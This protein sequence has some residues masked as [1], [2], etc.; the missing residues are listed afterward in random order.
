MSITIKKTLR[1][2][3]IDQQG[4][5]HRFELQKNQIPHLSQHL[6]LKKLSLIAKSP[7]YSFEFFLKTLTTH[8][9]TIKLCQQITLLLTTGLS[10]TNAI[11]F[12][13][14][15]EKNKVLLNLLHHIN[16]QL[17]Q[18][19]PL[20]TTLTQYPSYFNA[21]FC[22]IIRS[23]EA[24]GTLTEA[25]DLLT[26]EKQQALKTTAKLKKAL[27]Y[28]LLLLLSSLSASLALISTILP[29]FTHLFDSFNQSLPSFTLA[30]INISNT[31]KWLLPYT[32]G[33]S[34]ILLTS[35]LLAYRYSPKAK[36]ALQIC[37]LKLPIIGTIANNTHYMKLFRILANILQSQLSILEGL[38][39]CKQSTPYIHYKLKIEHT[40]QHIASG[41]SIYQAIKET[42]LFD[43]QSA[44]LIATAEYSHSL[45][46]IFISL[47][48]HFQNEFEHRTDQIEKLIGPFIILMLSLVIACVIIAIY[49][50]IFNMGN[51]M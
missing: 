20:S 36:K 41:H 51:M 13:I 8:Q 27:T 39:I 43:A 44:Q 9:I 24:T 6:K 37:F 14:T 18:G 15:T 38:E 19:T 29:K 7:R 42:G 33:S 28:P 35:T 46:S 23:A 40:H 3:G 1:C 49:L 4:Q 25:F 2:T 26:T 10:I 11:E 50:P 32:F 31:I 16:N 30:V 45:P 21:H 5:L 48:H 12:L 47:S 22:A 17:H 34:V